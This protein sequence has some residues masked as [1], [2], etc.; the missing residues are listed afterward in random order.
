MIQ[1]EEI[2]PK[3]KELNSSLLDLYVEKIIRKCQIGRNYSA[4]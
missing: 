1:K 2:L 4:G 3:R